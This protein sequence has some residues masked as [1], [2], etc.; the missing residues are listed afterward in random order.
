[1][2][3]IAD[4]SLIFQIRNIDKMTAD[5]LYSKTVRLLF[6]RSYR[7][8]RLKISEILPPI[9]RQTPFCCPRENR[10]RRRKPRKEAANYFSSFQTKSSL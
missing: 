7:S 4:F 10:R 6:C 5:G 9:L 8:L 2:A 1:M 3:S